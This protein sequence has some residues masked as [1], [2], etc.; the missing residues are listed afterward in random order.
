MISPG[1]NRADICQSCGNRCL[2]IV[3]VKTAQTP[4]DDCAVGS[5]GQAE[6]VAGGHGR[7]IGEAR[8]RR[9]IRERIA[10]RTNGSVRMPKAEPS[11]LRRILEVQLG[12]LFPLPA[13]Q[14]AWKLERQKLLWAMGVVLQATELSQKNGTSFRVNLSRI[15]SQLRQQGGSL[16]TTTSAV[17]YIKKARAILSTGIALRCEALFVP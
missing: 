2:A 3:D 14:M 13:D 12:Q 10:P 8:W 9:K 11:D 7:D 5:E 15:K 17:E 1:G 16:N 4:G 6:A